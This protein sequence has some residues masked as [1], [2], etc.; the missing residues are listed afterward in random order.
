MLVILCVFYLDYRSKISQAHYLTNW[1]KVVF[2]LL[3]KMKEIVYLWK[4]FSS[5]I[6]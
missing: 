3:G 1:C 6:D 2:I 4:I 5:V